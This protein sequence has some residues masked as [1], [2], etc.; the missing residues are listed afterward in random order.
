MGFTLGLAI[1]CWD[2]ENHVE[3]WVKSGE[4]LVGYGVGNLELV[5]GRKS[6]LK[7]GK[8]GAFILQSVCGLT[9]HPGTGK[10]GL[11]LPF[12]LPPLPQKIHI[13]CG[14][15][16]MVSPRRKKPLREYNHPKF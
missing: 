3:K 6:G 1:Q 4:I 2:V 9:T 13:F 15:Y 14:Y 12:F 11:N 10:N 16:I 5:H 7:W 8:F